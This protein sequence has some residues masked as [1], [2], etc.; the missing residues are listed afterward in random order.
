MHVIHSARWD[1]VGDLSDVRHESVGMHWF[2]VPGIHPCIRSTRPLYRLYL[3]IH[4]QLLPIVRL[5]SSLPAPLIHSFLP[6]TIYDGCMHID[7]KLYVID[8][9]K[10]NNVS[11]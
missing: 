7:V 8:E 3:N 2:R 1:V 9:M 6:L 5:L 10:K 4:C 11:C